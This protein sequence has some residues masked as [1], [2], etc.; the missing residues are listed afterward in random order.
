MTRSSAVLVVLG[1]PFAAYAAWAVWAGVRAELAAPTTPVIAAPD[2]KRLAEIRTRAEKFARDVRQTATVA[3]EVRG[4]GPGD[5]IE[6][7]DCLAL[8]RATAARAAD[9]T[10]VEQFLSGA[11]RPVYTGKLKDRFAEW[12]PLRPKRP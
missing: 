8:V 4:P 3:L 7:A 11:D 6:D 2:E 9:L 1:V 10:D 5:K 12:Q